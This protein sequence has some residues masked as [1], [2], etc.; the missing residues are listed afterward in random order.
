MP[1]VMEAPKAP[2]KETPQQ[3]GILFLSIYPEYDLQIN[4]TEKKI[5]KLEKGDF[6]E[7]ETSRT[8][9]FKFKTHRATVSEEQA[10]LWRRRGYYGIHFIEAYPHPGIP[11]GAASLYEML[12]AETGPGPAQA[13]QFLSQMEQKS[14]ARYAAGAA[15][16]FTVQNEIIRE[17]SK[18]QAREEIEKARAQAQKGK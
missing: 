16:M 1:E 17:G 6:R 18:R 7:I 12:T 10:A 8:R 5:V 15:K 13:R 9:S 4:F 3:K 14:N 2:I 11:R